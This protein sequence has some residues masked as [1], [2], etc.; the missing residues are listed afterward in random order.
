MSQPHGDFGSPLPQPAHGILPRQ[1]VQP[2]PR[3]LPLQQTPADAHVQRPLVRSRDLPRR[4]RI[5]TPREHP[6]SPP[7]LALSLGQWPLA[8]GQRL[9]NRHEVGMLRVPVERLQPSPLERPQIT[10]HIGPSPP[11]VDCIQLQM[12]PRQPQRQRQPRTQPDQFLPLPVGE[13]RIK[14]PQQRHPLPV[15]KLAD[16]ERRPLFQRDP[17]ARGDDQPAPAG[18]TSGPACLAFSALSST[19]SIRCPPSAW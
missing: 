4:R 7:P 8:E 5:K 18:G 2:I 1:V 15:I 16:F 11:P 3:L 17:H 6:Q 19:T 13:R 12:R 14:C 10:R 9:L